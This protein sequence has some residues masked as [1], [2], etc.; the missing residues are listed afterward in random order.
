REKYKLDKNLKLTQDQDVLDTWFSSAL[1]PF[2]T[3][4]WPEETNE[5]KNFYPTN[6]L[7]TGFDIIF[8]WVARM[9]MMGLK[10]TNKIPFKTIYI[11]G[12]VRDSE[13][14]KMSKS[15]GNIIDP[16]DIIDGINLQDLLDKRTSNLVQPKLEEK[17]IKKTKIEF[18]D[19]I[20]PYGADA[21]RFCFSALASTG[22][23]INFD[24]NRIEG[25]RNF[26]NKLWNASRFVFMTVDLKEYNQKI[27]Y[28][29]L[30]LYD[31]W[32]LTRLNDII[33]DYKK[34][35]S[36]FRFDLI[37]GSLY[38]FI[39][40]EYCDWY[41][42][43]AKIMIARGVDS[44]KD[45]LINSLQL[46][47]KLCHPIIP[48]ITE[49]IWEE[50]HKRNYTPDELL[51]N[52]KFPL[53]Q[54]LFLDNAVSMNVNTV[55][56]IINSIRK[57]RSDLNIHPKMEIDVYFLS[58]QPNYESII[59]ENDFIIQNLAKV[60][61]IF[62]NEKSYNIKDC[63]TIT[64]KDLKALIPIKKIIDVDQELSRLKKN[65]SL[66]ESLLDKV[67]QKINNKDFIEKAP[68]SIIKENL[69]KK[70][71]IQKEIISINELMK[72]LSD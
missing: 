60:N 43:I 50:M 23:D 55:M 65:L 11:H 68:S 28:E 46:I 34:H 70:D 49:E 71:N 64:L 4:G 21:L 36:S 61:K 52:S 18:P 66:L 7:V 31:K 54:K 63:I 57:T 30:S 27:N 10:F 24:L 51:I 5:F 25:Y 20:K 62:W 53:Q 29:S 16:I 33:S 9:V 22:R 67:N 39:W 37:A 56:D 41:L 58:N 38:S 8:F 6:V 42:E 26:C 3:L 72:Y 17:I 69:D 13:G 32:I 12:L 1:W 2:T 14:K 40:Y 44:T 15:L 45:T 48:Y 19:G 35:F 59:K 47:L